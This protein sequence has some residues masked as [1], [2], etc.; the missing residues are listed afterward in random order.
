MRARYAVRNAVAGIAL[1]NAAVDLAVS[2]AVTNV[3]IHAYRDRDPATEPGR[4]QVAL[5]VENHGIRIVVSDQGV[6]MSPR[7]DSPGLGLGL[8]LIANLCDELEIQ[9][10]ADGTSLHMRFEINVAPQ[11]ADERE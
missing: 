5:N 9:Q 10:R 3:I 1:D 2:E 8:P 6:G 4:V 11:H 7:P